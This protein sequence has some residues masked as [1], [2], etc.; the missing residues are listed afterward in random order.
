LEVTMSEIRV[1]H[2]E[3]LPC[4]RKKCCPTIRV[5]EDGSATLSD[6]DV[7]VGS[8]GTIKLQPEAA[9]RLVELLTGKR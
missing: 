5:F 2:E 7:E 8:T 4:G 6:D 9:A 3:M 1:V